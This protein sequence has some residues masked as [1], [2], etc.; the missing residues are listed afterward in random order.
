[1]TFVE[2]ADLDFSHFRCC[3]DEDLY[4]FGCPAC[5]RLMVLCYEC[6]T[7]YDD[8]RDLSHRERDINNFEPARPI[9]SCLGCGH[10][11]T[12]F[13][14][15]DGMYKVSHEQW[16]AAGLGHLLRLECDPP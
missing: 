6:D 8:L 1:V 11:F 13:F 5:R 15:R 2:E 10:P 3:G 9:F 7:L 4:P 16:A 14:V 12:Y